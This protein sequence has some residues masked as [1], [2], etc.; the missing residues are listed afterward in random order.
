MQGAG[1]Q[2]AHLRC[3]PRQPEPLA[4]QTASPALAQPQPVFCHCAPPSQP[5]VAACSSLA[6]PCHCPLSQERLRQ[7]ACRLGPSLLLICMRL[8][9]PRLAQG[10]CHCQQGRKVLAHSGQSL[11]PCPHQ[12]YP[13]SR[14]WAQRLRSYRS[15]R[16]EQAPLSHM[17]LPSYAASAS[18]AAEALMPLL[19]RPDSDTLLCQR[20]CVRW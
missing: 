16:P 6:F 7:A 12:W 17:E 2:A 11:P 15:L 8:R 14:A 20:L 5:E 3:T 10:H 19:Q 9:P 4:V 18:W 13:E 1:R